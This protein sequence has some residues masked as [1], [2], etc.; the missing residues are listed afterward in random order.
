M[1]EN[2]PPQLV[3]QDL[4][5][6]GFRQLGAEF[7][8]AWSL[9]VA[10]IGGGIAPTVV[11]AIDIGVFVKQITQLHQQ[12]AC[13]VTTALSMSSD[14]AAYTT[15]DLL[16]MIH[17][18]EDL[19]PDFAYNA[20]WGTVFGRW[21]KGIDLDPLIELLQSEK[22]SERQ[23]GAWY[24]DEASPPKDQIADIVIK[25]ADDPISHCRWR[26]VAYVT[27]SGLYSDAI[28]DRLAASLL[29]LDLY[30]RAET[31]FWAVWA[32]DANFDH[33][34]GVV[35]SG[36]GTKPYRFRNPQ[37]TA[38]WRES[39]RKRAARGIEIAQRL[40]AGESIASIRE[41]VP[42]EDSY[43]FDKLAFLDHAIKRALERRA[44]KAN[45]ASGP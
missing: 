9:V 8:E 30:V 3:A 14:L 24:L 17:G 37:T 43:S 39:E 22:S 33:F 21:R 16:R 5:D 41:S 44:Q 13:G 31:I 12:N 28:A 45:A 32:D 34:V 19:G 29:D 20:L 2:L 23:R 15:N 10:E 11:I 18:G 4:A 42:E 1:P 27:N 38:F 26:F 36:A 6:I 7:D 35:L 25:L 40:R